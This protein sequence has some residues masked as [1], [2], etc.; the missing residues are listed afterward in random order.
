MKLPPP[1]AFENVAADYAA[2]GLSLRA[3][4]M[5]FLRPDK[6][7]ATCVRASDL[8]SRRHGSLVA[9]AG[10]VT[11]R[12]RPSTAKGTLFVTLEDE[13]G[14]M[15]LVVW[16]SIQEHFCEVVFG[17]KLMLVKGRLEKNEG[18]VHIIAGYMEDRSADVGSLVLS[19]R[20]FH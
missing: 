11:G 15:N 10:L 7:Y 1:N 20:D 2:T 12:Q 3:H 14:N 5:S 6:P 19:S 17:A 16:K 9:V 13:T 18:V 4:P 8:I